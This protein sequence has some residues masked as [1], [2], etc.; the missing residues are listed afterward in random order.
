MPDTSFPEGSLK[1]SILNRSRLLDRLIDG[2][3]VTVKVLPEKCLPK[4]IYHLSEAEHPAVSSEPATYSGPLL[5][6]DEQHVYQLQDTTIMRHDRE[7]FGDAAHMSER[8][9]AGMRLSVTYHLG[10]RPVVRAA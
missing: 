3:W 10:R 6:V 7:T 8:L 5:L 1:L 2:Q 9:A 4:G